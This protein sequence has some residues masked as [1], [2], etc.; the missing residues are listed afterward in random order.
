MS[1]GKRFALACAAGAMAA[2]LGGCG[3][4]PVIYK[5]GR[6]QGKLDSKPWNNDRFKGNQAEWEKAVKARS[7]G[8][9]EYSRAVASAN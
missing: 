6:Y 2:V 8:Q 1:A 5:E 7:Q 3:D 4:K 9:D